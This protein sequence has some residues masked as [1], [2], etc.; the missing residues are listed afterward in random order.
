M[1]VNLRKRYYEEDPQRRRASTEA[2]LM[3]NTIGGRIA[4]VRAEARELDGKLASEDPEVREKALQ[5]SKKL[6]GE[7]VGLVDKA[8]K[9]KNKDVPWEYIEGMEKSA[10]GDASAQKM[11]ATPEKASSMLQAI[12][13]DDIGVFQRKLD[14]EFKA[15]DA[16]K[17]PKVPVNQQARL[18]EGPQGPAL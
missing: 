7:F 6:L 16:A 2:A 3:K 4:D 1:V 14:S 11:M 17:A 12:A 9:G 5:Q 15:I 10:L 8:R 18:E 13:A